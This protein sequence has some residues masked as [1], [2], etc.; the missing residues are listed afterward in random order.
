MKHLKGFVL[1]AALV[2]AAGGMAGAQTQMTST[3]TNYST[4]IMSMNPIDAERVVGSQQL[5]GIRLDDSGKGP[6]HL[7]TTYVVCIF[8]GDKNGLQMRAFATEMDKDGDKVIWEIWDSP[9]GTPQG[10]G[11]LVG[12]TGKFAGMEGTI[13]FE[14]QTPKGFPDSTGRVIC[15]E[16]WH[17]TLKNPL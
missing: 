7:L 14:I 13:D 15:R 12:A 3:G 6:F 2:F 1:C 4:A 9:A 17:V 16:V 11:K 10:K 5:T 8:Y